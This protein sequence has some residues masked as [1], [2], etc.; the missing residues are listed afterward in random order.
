MLS[1]KC[2]FK[3]HKAN[4]A[5]AC[6]KVWPSIFERLP[7]NYAGFGFQLLPR[8]ERVQCAMPLNA[9]LTVRCTEAGIK[10]ALR[11]FSV[12]SYNSESNTTNH[13]NLSLIALHIFCGLCTSTHTRVSAGILH[14]VQLTGTLA[15]G[16]M[17]EYHDTWCMWQDR[18][19]S[20]L[21]YSRSSYRCLTRNPARRWFSLWRDAS[22][23]DS[24]YSEFCHMHRTR[25]D[26]GSQLWYVLLGI[27]H[28][29]GSTVINHSK[30]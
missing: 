7:F 26:Q 13:I 21:S 30:I 1:G 4:T 15:E 25:E 29:F 16:I 24:F 18:T 12:I 10:L 8:A 14:N 6:S 20:A 3:S 19:A 28:C 27:S 22:H 2:H 17:Y 23:V 11:N 5:Y 9:F